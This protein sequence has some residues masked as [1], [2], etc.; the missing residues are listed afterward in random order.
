[1]A[2]NESNRL[3]PQKP[4]DLNVGGAPLSRRLNRT[5]FK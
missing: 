4:D 2:G 3:N 5:L 1:M